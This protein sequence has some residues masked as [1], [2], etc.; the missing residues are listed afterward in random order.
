MT[1]NVQNTKNVDGNAVFV[2]GLPRM[3]GRE[4][5][6]KWLK[7][8]GYIAKLDLPKGPGKTQNRGYGYVHF[9]DPSI[10]DRLI[11]EREFKFK[12]YDIVFEPYGDRRA[13]DNEFDTVS[14]FSEDLAISNSGGVNESRSISPQ[15]ILGFPTLNKCLE[16]KNDNGCDSN[17]N[18]L[19]FQDIALMLDEIKAN[20]SVT[21]HHNENFYLDESHFSSEKLYNLYRTLLG[22]LY[23]QLETSN[24]GIEV[25][26]SEIHDNYF[27]TIGKI[28]MSEAG[29]S[30]YSEFNH[31]TMS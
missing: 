5:I 11:K 8:F 6:Y 23:Q 13:E 2:C 12:K 27:S 29:V 31:C 28:W 1:E 25:I 16:N 15:N 20:T 18:Y 26:T 9:V 4:K 14:G 21:W 17:E 19:L 7:R 22:S 30:D 24:C 10:C 3:V